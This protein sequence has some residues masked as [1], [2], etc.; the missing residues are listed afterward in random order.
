MKHPL[1]IALVCPYNMFERT[2]GVQ[3]LVTHLHNGLV[4]KGHIVRIIT[5]RPAGFTGE[6]PQ[7]YILF[8][9]SRNFK[10]GFGTSGNLGMPADGAQ[11]ARI[12]NEE[13]FD[14][15]NFHEP[16]LPMLA[17]QM[18]KHS[19]SA[20][21][22]TFHANLA[23]T[24]AGKSWTSSVFKPYARPL[25][26]KMDLFTAAS[27]AASAMLISRANMKL[28]R[29][30]QLIGGIKYIPNGIDLKIYKPPKKRQP[31]NGPNTKTIVYIGRLERRKGV[32]WLLRA[33]ALLEAKMP[34]VYLI[35]AGE[36]PWRDKLEQLADSH[37]IK[38]IHFSGYV[39]DEEK[40]RLMGNA[41]VF[42]SPA[43]FGESFGIVLT[44]A[45]AMGAPVVAGRN[46]GYIN[47]LTGSGRLGLVDPRATEDFADRLELIATD[48][49]VN[50]LLRG[51]GLREVKKY[52][53]PKIVDQYEAA[54]I[55]ALQQATDEKNGKS[56]AKNEPVK[57]PF[58]HR[59]L[60]R[61]HAR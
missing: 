29:D 35:I 54:Y 57:K 46:S 5:Q 41:D 26:E 18:I 28:K 48:E 34:N 37:D 32:D 25:L 30:R 12:L 11:I 42:C 59:L 31:L 15:I 53:Y 10:G 40:R 13:Q 43:I 56:V 4:K 33:F 55:G 9:T 44:E 21:V 20:H 51:W 49:K 14:V 7:D 39:E 36:G 52:D 16:W 47:V 27:P 2:G 50:R 22:A 23:D 61:R 3:Q 24:T 58:I 1:K 19:K 8:G 60:I 17:W 45:M 6:I 38:N